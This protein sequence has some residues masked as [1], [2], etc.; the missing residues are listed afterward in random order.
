MSEISGHEI[1]SQLEVLKG[2]KLRTVLKSSAN[3]LFIV[4]IVC[5]PVASIV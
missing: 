5:D 2:V 3:Y 1:K 4:I